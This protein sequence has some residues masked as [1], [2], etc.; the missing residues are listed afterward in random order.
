M[1]NSPSSRSVI[2]A[3]IQQTS[4][5]MAKGVLELSDPLIFY[6]LS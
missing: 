3:N 2:S 6:K 4:G 5:E 1:N